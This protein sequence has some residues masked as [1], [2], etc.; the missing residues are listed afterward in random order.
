MLKSI[1]SLG[2][3]LS[4][5]EQQ[6]VNGGTLS[7]EEGATWEWVYAYGQWRKILCKKTHTFNS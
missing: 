2:T 1:S 4:K 6:T 3:I 5:P 7:C